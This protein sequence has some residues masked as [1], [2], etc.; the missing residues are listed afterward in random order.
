ML[1]EG[2]SAGHLVSA[3]SDQRTDEDSAKDHIK[4][5]DPENRST[6][7]EDNGSMKW[8]CSKI[9]VMRRMLHSDNSSGTDCYMQAKSSNSAYHSDRIN[10]TD[11]CYGS[12]AEVVRVCSD[13]KTTK[14]PLWRGGPRG[15]KV[16]YLYVYCCLILLEF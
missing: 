1:A 5:V 16:I 10:S 8:M 9:R 2:S 15:P 11:Y 4:M 6:S 3:S 7:T 14:T 13:C 12:T